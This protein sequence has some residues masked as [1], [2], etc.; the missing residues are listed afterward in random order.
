MP[1]DTAAERTAAVDAAAREPA[2][3]QAEVAAVAGSRA[4]RRR[5]DS[6]RD[7]SP[8]EA[9]SPAAAAGT[10][11]DSPVQAGNL[12]HRRH[13]LAGIRIRSAGKAAAAF[14][15]ELSVE[16]FRQWCLA[17]ASSRARARN[18]WLP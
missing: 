12:D 14:R 16:G 6:R 10:L 17:C 13:I 7:R 8:A 9:D 4:L 18:R 3:V 5:P 15:V 2:Q 11:A 1:V